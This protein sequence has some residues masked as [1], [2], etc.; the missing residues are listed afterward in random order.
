MSGPARLTDHPVLG[1]FERGPEVEFTFD[2]APVRGHA[3][4]PV[5]VA[6]LAA[7]IWGLR[8][9]RDGAE[10]G[11]YCAIGQCME[12][13]VDVAGE[14]TRRACVT[15]LR[16]GMSVTPHDERGSDA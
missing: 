11:L 8:I 4:E 7:G 12:C 10:R 13:R 3:G 2:G 15:P 5:G 14:G 16:A 9:A 1:G 6:L